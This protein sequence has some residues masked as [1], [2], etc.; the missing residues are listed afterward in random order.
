MGQIYLVIQGRGGA[1]AQERLRNEIIASQVFQRIKD[2]CSKQKIGAREGFEED[3]Q[4]VYQQFMESKLTAISGN[5]CEENLGLIESE[6][7]LLKEKVCCL[8]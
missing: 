3:E 7:S 8:E 1:S 2:M 4:D 5:L 6:K